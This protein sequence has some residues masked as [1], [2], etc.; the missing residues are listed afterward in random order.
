MFEK[1]EE[2][3]SHGGWISGSDMICSKKGKP[4]EKRGKGFLLPANV[5]RN[6]TCWR[7][8][9]YE[10][11]DRHEMNEI[12]MKNIVNVVVFVLNLQNKPNFPRINAY[13]NKVPTCPTSALT[14]QRFCWRVEKKP[15]QTVQPLF[16]SLI[17]I[18]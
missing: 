1:I 6:I 9:A 16:T 10:L 8:I 3:R 7:N 18:L 12:G 2:G 15:D 4:G 13:I 14:M 17:P 11:H 5:K